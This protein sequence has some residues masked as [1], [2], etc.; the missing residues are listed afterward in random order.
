MRV[1]ILGVTGMLGSALYKRFSTNTR[2]ETWGTLRDGAGRKFFGDDAQARLIDGVDVT[3]NDSLVAVM[4]RVRP[5]VVVNAVGIV[6]QLTTANDPLVVLPINALLPHRLALIC[7]A[8]GA[9]LVHISSDCVFSGRKGN[10]VELD[11]SDAEDLYGKSKFIG[12]V[13]DKPHAITLRTSGIGHELNSRNGLV[14]WFLHQNGKVKGFTKAIFSGLPWVETA[15]VISDFVLPH[16]EISGLYHL[17]AEPIS[18]FDLLQLISR[19]YG[20]EIKI[21]PDNT[22][23]IDRSLNGARFAAA[24]GYKAP[25][26]PAL[27]ELMHQYRYTSSGA[28]VGV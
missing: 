22:V 7:G 10:Y 20:K 17:A 14:E 11:A 12:E 23:H 28:S 26:W 19:V 18:K 1:L 15:R 5:T 13:I 25:E 6:K 9:R 4:E 2:L 16:G 24:T 27:I 3:D 8:K 21:E